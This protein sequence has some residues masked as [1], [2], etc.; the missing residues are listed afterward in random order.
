M[1][2]LLKAFLN[3]CVLFKTAEFVP[4]LCGALFYI[5]IVAETITTVLLIK[6]L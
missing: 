4:R 1:K 3:E 5:F 6:S 2:E